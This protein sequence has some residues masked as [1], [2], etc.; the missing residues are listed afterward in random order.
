M[1]LL[2][3]DLLHIQKLIAYF[4]SYRIVHHTVGDSSYLY[5]KITEIGCFLYFVLNFVVSRNK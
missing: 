5:H 1:G 3:L 2:G 4:F